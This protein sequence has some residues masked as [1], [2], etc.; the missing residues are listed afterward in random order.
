MILNKIVYPLLILF[1][2][3]DVKSIPENLKETMTNKNFHQFKVKTID[4][5]ELN[6]SDFKGK[7]V[8]VVNVASQCGYTPQYKQLQELYER[9][10]DKGFEIIAFPSNDFGGQEPGTNQEIKNFCERN[11]GVT[12][13]V[14]EKIAVIG[15]N[16]H[17]LYK[18]L[19]TKQENGWNDQAPTWNFCKYLIDEN[20]NLVKYYSSAVSPLDD[21]ILKELN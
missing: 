14:C 16:Q 9:K 20:G 11:Y 17:P 21:V 6:L 19:T 7:K 15:Q 2:C 5:K 12:F 8:L 4:G 13:T 10:K 18:W 1:G 3:K